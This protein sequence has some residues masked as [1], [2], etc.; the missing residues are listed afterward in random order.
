MDLGK[1]RERSRRVTGLSGI[2]SVNGGLDPVPD[3]P[4]SAAECGPL[5]KLPKRDLV[6]EYEAE[7]TKSEPAPSPVSAAA[8]TPDSSIESF[9][10]LFREITDF[11]DT[12]YPGSREDDCEITVL[13]GRR[14]LAFQVVTVESKEP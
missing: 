4:G 11:A 10:A 3:A 9:V 6:A 7:A 8:V 12:V 2:V 5:L 1:V 14:R 13:V